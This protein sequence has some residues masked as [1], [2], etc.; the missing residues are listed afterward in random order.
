M[1]CMTPQQQKAFF[2]DQGYLVVENVLGESELAACRDEIQRLHKFAADFEKQDPKKFIAHFQREPFE[3]S[4]NSADGLPILRKIEQSDLFSPLFAKIAEHP[5][6]I[7]A[8]QN[9]LDKD[10]LLFRST[11]MLKPAH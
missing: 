9:L 10:L 2:E 4:K 6:L 7:A 1:L 11:L 5:K 8:V 3:A